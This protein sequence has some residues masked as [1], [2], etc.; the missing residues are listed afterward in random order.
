MGRGNLLLFIHL[1][2]QL[3]GK[4]NLAVTSATPLMTKVDLT[5]MDGY[6]GD[7]SSLITPY[8]PPELYSDLERVAF[9]CRGRQ[10]PSKACLNSCTL[11]KYSLKNNET[12]TPRLL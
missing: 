3:R 5:D 7:P 4:V 10:L 2:H 9:S 1:S 8:V 6:P 11:Y 12:S